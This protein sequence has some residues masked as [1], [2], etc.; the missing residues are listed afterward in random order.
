MRAGVEDLGGSSPLRLSRYDLLVET[1]PLDRLWQLTGVEH[2]LNSQPGLYQPAELLAELP[3]TDGA[4]YLHRL[5]QPAP[6][7]WVVNAVQSLEDGPALPLLADA[8]FDPS[9]TA[10]LP[11][12]TDTAGRAGFSPEG[13]LALPGQNTIQLQQLAPGRLRVDVQ[14]ERGGL[15]MVSENW[16]PGWQATVRRE[17]DEESA[18]AAVLRADV[19]FLGVPINPGHSV[20]ELTYRPASV[21]LGLMISGVTLALLLGVLVWLT[22]SRVRAARVRDPRPGRITVD[23]DAGRKLPHVAQEATHR[24]A[25]R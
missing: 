2:V 21:R 25:E 10:L 6:R 9:A 15:L 12:V 22:R 16:L 24:P 5:A 20:V 14:S 23:E 1:F 8:R 17:G 3:G 4:S 19:A 7:A 18:P 13:L 11:P